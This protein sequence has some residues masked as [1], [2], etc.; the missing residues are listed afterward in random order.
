MSICLLMHVTWQLLGHVWAPARSIVQ[1]KIR[2]C[3][4]ACAC[5]QFYAKYGGKTIVLARFV[6]IIR[7]FAPFVAGVG[8]M[9]YPRFLAFNVA[10]AL[11]WT[12]LFTG[13]S[14]SF[15][16]PALQLVGWPM[17]SS[18]PLPELQL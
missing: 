6:P 16:C 14:A 15:A 11:I 18:L 17:S 12:V 13:R 5:L 7:T 9:H 1:L 8:A 10:G 2:T 3:R 4:R